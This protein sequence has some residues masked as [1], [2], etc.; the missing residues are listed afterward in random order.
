MKR[1]V[2]LTVVATI[3][4]SGCSQTIAYQGLGKWTPEVESL[5]PVSACQGGYCCPEGKCQWPLALTVPPPVEVYHRALVDDAVRRFDV[6]A[7]EVV[8]D[9]VS[10]KL[11]T[12]VVGTVRGWSAEGIAGKAPANAASERRD[13]PT[14]LTP[15]ERLRQLEDLHRSGL[16]TDEEY[17]LKRSTIIDGL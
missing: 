15:D 7:N 1:F 8:L 4:C 5:G 6:G 10:V 12:E 14:S 9:K 16:V 17:Q 2:I 3:F 11:H 13:H